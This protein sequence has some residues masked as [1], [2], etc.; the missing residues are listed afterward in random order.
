LN[1]NSG[2]Q[3]NDILDSQQ[4]ELVF[5]PYI[6]LNTFISHEVMDSVRQAFLSQTKQKATLSNPLDNR[7]S[8]S[9]TAGK[10][11]LHLQE[12]VPLIQ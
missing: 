2:K 12:Y 10:A 8:G 6:L 11:G 1:K 5:C 7:Y 3:I 4:I 9:I